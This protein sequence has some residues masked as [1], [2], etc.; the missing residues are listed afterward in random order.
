MNKLIPH[1]HNLKHGEYKYRIKISIM[2]WFHLPHTNCMKF[3]L[4]NLAASCS[5]YFRVHIPSSGHQMC[6]CSFA[7]KQSVSRNKTW[8]QYC[9]T[10]N[11]ITWMWCTLRCTL[12][13]VNVW[14]PWPLTH[15]QDL[16][17]KRIHNSNRVSLKLFCSFYLHIISYFANFLFKCT[18]VKNSLPTSNFRSW[19]MVS[20]M[21]ILP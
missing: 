11:L 2:A 10:Q 13:Y 18:R 15:L 17:V 21:I 9:G 4:L 8:K 16:W 20:F 6:H 19:M 12:H 3:P 7:A 14:G 5:V 1:C